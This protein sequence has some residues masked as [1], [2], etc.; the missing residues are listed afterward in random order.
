MVSDAQAPSVVGGAELVGAS[1]AVEV[2]DPSAIVV[3]VVP[4][5]PVDVV[6]MAVLDVTEPDR[7]AAT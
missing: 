4:G 6:A 1:G 3:A 7:G 5:S 2:D